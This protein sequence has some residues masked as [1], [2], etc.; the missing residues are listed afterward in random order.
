MHCRRRKKNRR[1]SEESSGGLDGETS[2]SLSSGTGRN[3]TPAW[4]LAPDDREV[5]TPSS[6][7]PTTIDNHDTFRRFRGPGPGQLIPSNSIGFLRS[8]CWSQPP[9]SHD[10]PE[11]ACPVLTPAPPATRHIEASSQQ[12]WPHRTTS[13]TAPMEKHQTRT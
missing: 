7:A 10:P 11:F 5:K 3:S 9:S 1:G 4:L 12:A 13:R 6:T 8:T 2:G